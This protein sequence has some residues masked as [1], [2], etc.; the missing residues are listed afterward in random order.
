MARRVTGL[1]AAAQDSGRRFPLT[2]VPRMDL[3]VEVHRWGADIRAQAQPAH[4]ADSD[5][6][7]VGAQHDARRFALRIAS[8]VRVMRT[9][10]RVVAWPG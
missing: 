2:I 1:P 3:K 4:A 10:A 5:P 8:E 7:A 6:P 9:T